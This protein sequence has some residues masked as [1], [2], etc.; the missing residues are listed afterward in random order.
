[1][2]KILIIRFSS[3]G[4]IVLT[5]PII[6]CLKKQIPGIEIH[7]VTKSQYK[8]IIIGNPYITKIFTFDKSISELIP[9]LKNENYDFIIDL[10]R[11]IRSLSLLIR[12][13]KP[14]LTFNKINIRKWLAV[15]FKLKV[16][17]HKHIVDRYFDS[18]KNLNVVNDG[19]GLDCFIPIADNLTL[20][21][22]PTTHQSGY[23]ALV[24]GAKFKTKQF[25]IERVIQLIHSSSK[26]FILL[27]GAEDYSEGERIASEIG[28]RVFNACGKFNINQSASLINLSEKVITNDTGLMHIAAALQKDIISLWGNT[29]PEF[30]MYPYFAENSQGKSFILEVKH[31]KCRPCSKIGFQSC[32]KGHF[33][34]MNKIPISNII[35]KID[36]P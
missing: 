6:R 25:P 10:H 24:I 30:G 1:M 4:D 29:I 12:L 18:V 23:V 3:I 36:N 13:W 20:E 33:D 21:Q 11:N 5:T 26:N 27:G 19:Q 7:F 8:S 31:L 14:F 32:P 22:L 15:N 34:C 9:E 28:S 2:K 16:L 17:P 35:E